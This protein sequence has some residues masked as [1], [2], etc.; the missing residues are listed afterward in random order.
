MQHGLKRPR[1]DAASSTGSG[2]TAAVLATAAIVTEDFGALLATSVGAALPA[3][4]ADVGLG[5]T[6]GFTAAYVG[7]GLALSLSVI[8]AARSTAPAPSLPEPRS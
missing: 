5:R 2:L 4:F 3:A 7:F 6:A 8:A 1:F